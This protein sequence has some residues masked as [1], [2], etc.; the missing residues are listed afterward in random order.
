MIHWPAVKIYT[1]T[2]DDGTT[3]LI[4]PERVAKSDPRIEACGAVDELN[5]A[6]GVAA[7]LD[8]RGW[9][10][11]EVEAFQPALFEIGA[12]LATS[13]PKAPLHGVSDDDIARLE[14]TI[15][16][17]ESSLP[18]LTRFILPGGTPLAAQLHVARTVCRRAER[19]VVALGVESETH[20]R[21]IRY[22]NRLSD[23]LFVMARASNR[24]SGAAEIEWLPAAPGGQPGNPR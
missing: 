19:R 6:L 7:T 10:R 12:A 21:V 18:P 14:N 3:G 15:D 13:T 1:R 17:L 16:E 5:A 23:L 8:D 9:F 24:R 22:L 2:G 11:R 20:A 4:G